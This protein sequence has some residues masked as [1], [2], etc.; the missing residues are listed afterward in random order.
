MFKE[1]LEDLKNRFM[2]RLSL[3][4]VFSREAVDAPLY[5]GRLDAVRASTEVAQ[6]HFVRQGEARGLGHAVLCARPVVGNEPFAVL[7]GD[8]LIGE[9]ARVAESVRPD[10]LGR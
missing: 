9:V 6:V 5:A 7:L 2:T 10:V 1:E 8:D 3:H 4:L